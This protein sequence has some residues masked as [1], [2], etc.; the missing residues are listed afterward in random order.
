MKSYYVIYL[1]T[2]YNN[3]ISILIV[4]LLDKNRHLLMICEE[5]KPF[6][7][8]EL[9]SW[10]LCNIDSTKQ[11]N[12]MAKYCSR[13]FYI[14][15]FHSNTFALFLFFFFW[16]LVHP[17]WEKR[18]NKHIRRMVKAKETERLYVWECALVEKALSSQ[19]WVKNI[20]NIEIVIELWSLFVQCLP[21][22]KFV[23]NVDCVRSNLWWLCLENFRVNC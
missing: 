11:L 5:K 19:L 20:Y 23:L 14:L 15:A 8:L 16:K 4:A 12:R 9:L 13:L 6:I 21:I 22:K 10:C 1:I 17:N 3:Q 7:R 2:K 18:R